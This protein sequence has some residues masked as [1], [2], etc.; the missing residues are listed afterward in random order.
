M[1]IIVSLKTEHMFTDLHMSNTIKVTCMLALTICS[2]KT[3]DKAWHNCLSRHEIMMNR[4][5]F[6]LDF[7][8]F[9]WIRL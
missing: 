7:L 3:E 2:Q 8:C 6:Y 4:D 5:Q 9:R 1:E